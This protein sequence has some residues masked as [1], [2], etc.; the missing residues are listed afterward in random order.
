MKIQLVQS[1]VSEALEKKLGLKDMMRGA[2]TGAAATAALAAVPHQA[3]AP[4]PT[5]EQVQQSSVERV[6]KDF[7][8]HPEDKFLWTIE[9]IESSGGKNIKHKP[10]IHG[11]SRGERAIGRWG[12]MPK[13]VREIVTRMSREGKATPAEHAIQ[14]MDDS[15]M[16]EH[17]NHNPELELRLARR[18]AQHVLTRQR[19]DMTRAAYAW[20]EGHNLFPQDIPSEKLFNHRYVNMFNT[21]HRNNPIRTQMHKKSEPGAFVAK[22]QAWKRRRFEQEIVP[23]PRQSNSNTDMGRERE[24]ELDY[25]APKATL[26]DRLRDCL[27]DAR[28]TGSPP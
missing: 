13:T 27:T 19:G 6:K 3:L 22:F 21:F 20:D 15:S 2:A 26:R 16:T 28:K 24:T 25:V 9:Q 17:L 12:L 4:P 7:G 18:L 1:Q 8:T 23:Q 14:Q 11:M 10:V 5:P